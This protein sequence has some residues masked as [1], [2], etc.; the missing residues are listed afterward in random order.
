T[1]AEVRLLPVWR[2]STRMYRAVLRADG[3][4]ADPRDH[5]PAVPAHAGPWTS[6]RAMADDDAPAPIWDAD[7][8]DS[9]LIASRRGRAALEVRRLT[10]RQGR[11]NVREGGFNR[12]IVG[13]KELRL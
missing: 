2:R 11:H 10:T 8:A 4:R 7:G 5:R 3:G 9:A 12:R 13:S 1:A 6:G